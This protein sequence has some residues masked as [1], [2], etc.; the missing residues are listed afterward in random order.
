M[1]SKGGLLYV[2][3]YYEVVSPLTS[4]RNLQHTPPASS[5]NPDQLQ[6]RTLLPRVTIF[7]SIFVLWLYIKL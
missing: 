7:P 6:T 2:N 4:L 5:L 3:L 1:L